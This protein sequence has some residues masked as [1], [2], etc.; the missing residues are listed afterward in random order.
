MLKVQKQSLSGKQTL[1]I[2]LLSYNIVMLFFL[3][4]F[5]AEQ[6][7]T[8]A[9][10]SYQ[11]YKRSQEFFLLFLKRLY[12]ITPLYN[13]PLCLICEVLCENITISSQ[14]DTL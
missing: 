2:V 1:K 12:W 10:G 6:T 11:K 14:Q 5:K 7:T 8:A 13:H 4:H 3:S 9:T